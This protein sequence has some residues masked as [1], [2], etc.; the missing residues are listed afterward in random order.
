MVQPGGAEVV[1]HVGGEPFVLAEHDT[2]HDSA[3]GAVGPARHGTLDPVP[4]DVAEAG[5]PASPPDLAPARRLE[6][7]VDSLARKPRALVEAV[8]LRPWLGDPDRRLQDGSARRR[9]PDRENEQHALADRL[10]PERSRHGDDSRRPLATSA[11]VR[12]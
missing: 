11:Q 1:L 5:E 12:P 7:D 9:A 8:L 10:V 2:E 6:H 3:T 4:E